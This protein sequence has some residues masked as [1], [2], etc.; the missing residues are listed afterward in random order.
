M[1]KWGL[2][3]EARLNRFESNGRKSREEI[4]RHQV[5]RVVPIE[6]AMLQPHFE[7]SVFWGEIIKAQGQSSAYE[8]DEWVRCGLADWVQLNGVNASR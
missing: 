5:R 6:R 1:R 7:R 8:W 3:I 4:G 2:G